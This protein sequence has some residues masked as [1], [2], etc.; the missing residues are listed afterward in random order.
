MSFFWKFT[1]PLRGVERITTGGMLSF[2]PPVGPAAL[3]AQEAT[4]NIKIVKKKIWYN[5]INLNIFSLKF[6][7]L[8]SIPPR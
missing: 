7:R 6:S 4:V 8:I 3:L 1:A 5:L 2:G